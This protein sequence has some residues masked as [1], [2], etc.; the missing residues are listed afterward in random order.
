MKISH[1]LGWAIF[2]LTGL[3]AACSNK[4]TWTAASGLP[5]VASTAANSRLR[6]ARSTKHA[7]PPHSRGQCTWAKACPTVCDIY[8]HSDPV[9]YWMQA[10][11]L[12]VFCSYFPLLLP[13]NFISCPHDPL[14]QLPHILMCWGLGCWNMVSQVIWNLD[15]SALNQKVWSFLFARVWCT[16]VCPHNLW[17]HHAP[18]LLILLKSRFSKATLDI[19]LFRSMTLLACRWY[20]LVWLWFTNI[21][22]RG[23]SLTE[24]GT[25]HPV[26]I[27][28]FRKPEIRDHIMNRA[29]TNV[30]AAEIV[31][32][33]AYRMKGFMSTSVQ[34]LSLVTNGIGQ[35]KS[36]ATTCCSQAAYRECVSYR[37]W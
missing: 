13:Q 9:P 33:S 1:S 2:L 32:A 27:N 12:W 30:K 14:S 29:Q 34:L 21:S 7:P 20:G 23:H 37:T 36:T 17:Q 11:I 15:L 8:N 10:E 6:P 22:G 35:T 19:L 25:G 31:K 28:L 18:F 16:V 3:R 26:H 24:I 5:S 4:S